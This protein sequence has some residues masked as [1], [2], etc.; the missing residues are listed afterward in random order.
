MKAKKSLG[1]N[2][3]NSR[4]ALIEM[5]KSGNLQPGEFVL[6]IGPGNGA[7]TRELLDAKV[8][9]VTIE[10][11]HRLIPTLNETF[12]NEI[13]NGSLK[14]VE[15]DILEIELNKLL[16]CKYK[17]IANIPY[18]ITGL[19]IRKLLEEKNK[20]ESISLLVQKEVAERIVA[21]DGKE[22]ILSIS[23]KAFGDPKYIKTV[24]RGAF[25]PQPNV[26]SA[27]LKIGNISKNKIGEADEVKFFEI[28]KLGFS[29][30]RKHLASN[31]SLSHKKE[32]VRSAHEALGLREGERAEDLTI[33]TWVKLCNIIT[34]N[35]KNS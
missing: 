25:T 24:P 29:H 20:P 4:T 17:V 8:N 16:P 9:V 23:V 12:S 30:K 3:L 33:E 31:L 13:Q 5:V 21:K 6:E 7:L 15:G 35:E 32:T 18:Y 2:F 22:S 14:L 1:Q 26:D 28:V 27:I 19:I 10:K 34:Q 11:D